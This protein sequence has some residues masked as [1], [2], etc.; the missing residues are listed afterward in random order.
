MN[1]GA[2]IVNV[3]SLA[4]AAWRTTVEKSKALL[5]VGSMDGISAFIEEHEVDQENC[6]ELSKEATIVWGMQ[7]WNRWEDRGIRV[8]TVSPS[9]TKTPILGDFMT[10]VAVRQKAKVKPMEGLPGPG[11]AEDIAPIIAFLAGDD[12]R[13]LNGTNIIADGGLFAARTGQMMGF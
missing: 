12:S 8:N 2:A 3:A 4:G 10:T 5:A 13:W 7:C 1:D 11:S 6:Y 9:A